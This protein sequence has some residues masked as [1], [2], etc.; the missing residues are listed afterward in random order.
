MNLLV[1]GKN[2]FSYKMN[3]NVNIESSIIIYNRLLSSNYLI[4]LIKNTFVKPYS[5]LEIYF[6]NYHEY[7]IFY[8]SIYPIDNYNHN[9]DIMMISLK[10]PNQIQQYP[11]NIQELYI[12]NI[13]VFNEPPNL[14]NLPKNI[15]K[16]EIESSN[17]VDL[18]NLP[19]E[20][21]ELILINCI[22]NLDS[23]PTSLKKLNIQYK[24]IDINYLVNLP[25][26]LEIIK[27]N[28]VVY[29]GLDD[30]LINFI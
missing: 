26:Q 27:I 12:D 18:T 28:N 30:L 15:K 24:W 11:T 21:T 8:D 23:I 16:I 29:N 13:C 20:L 7:K 9:C 10:L 17:D 19:N 2:L 3:I 14:S 1:V 5:Y 22:G 25:P 4:K 6:E